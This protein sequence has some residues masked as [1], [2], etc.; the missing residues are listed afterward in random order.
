MSPI[1][2]KLN[3]LAEPN[4]PRRLIARASP[5]RSPLLRYHLSPRNTHTHMSLSPLSS[6][7]RF[8]QNKTELTCIFKHWVI[9]DHFSQINYIFDMLYL[10]IIHFSSFLPNNVR[11]STNFELIFVQTL[12]ILYAFFYI[13]RPK[14]KYFFLG[15]YLFEYST[16][17]IW[18]YSTYKECIFL[19]IL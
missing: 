5:H 2:A 11:I 13:F 8:A 14:S 7:R 16:Q 19:A 12:R 6:F 9:R 4:P 10:P 3:F 15:T 1:F 18:I 17:H